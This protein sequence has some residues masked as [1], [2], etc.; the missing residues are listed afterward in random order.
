MDGSINHPKW[1][2]IVTYIYVASYFVSYILIWFTDTHLKSVP[3]LFQNKQHL[4]TCARC[5]MVLMTSFEPKP[6][7]ESHAKNGSKCVI[8]IP[9]VSFLHWIWHSQA[10]WEYVKKC[11]KCTEVL[12]NLKTVTQIR[13]SR[14]ALPCVQIRARNGAREKIAIYI[15]SQ[16]LDIKSQKNITGGSQD[17]RLWS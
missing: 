14:H 6:V 12:L 17:V 5:K 3:Q 2:R 11:H 9:V 1:N 7:N 8:S 4:S 10:C 16:I 13:L 15:A